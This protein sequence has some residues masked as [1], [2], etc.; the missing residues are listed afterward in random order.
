MYASQVML[1]L[2]FL[3]V[4]GAA[5]F[6]LRTGQIPNYWTLGGLVVGSVAHLVVFSVLSQ[7]SGSMGQILW[8]AVSNL[9]LGVLFCFAVPYLLFRFQAMGGGDVK[10]LAGLG[11]F[12]GPLLGIEAQLYSFVVLALYAP[13]LLAY[14]GQLFSSLRNTARLFLNPLLPERKRK[15]VPSELLTSFRFAPA[16]LVGVSLLSLVR[17][18]AL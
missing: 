1:L 10:L 8:G 7:D 16:V 3:Y 13:A 14:R 4:L 17:W 18:G 5:V 9:A 12:L 6:D 2:A 11:A 15:E